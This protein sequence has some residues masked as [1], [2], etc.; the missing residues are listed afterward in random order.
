MTVINFKGKG[1]TDDWPH[2]Y[3]VYYKGNNYAKKQIET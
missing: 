2:Q 1:N 3:H